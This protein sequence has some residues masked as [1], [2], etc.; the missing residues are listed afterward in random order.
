[1]TKYHGKNMRVYVDGYDISGYTNSIDVQN[2]ADTV[3][4]GAFSSTAKEYVV[5]LFDSGIEHAGFFEDTPV[6]GGH[7]VL[8]GRIGSAVHFMALIG[9]AAPGYGFA[10]SAELENMYSLEASISGAITHKSKLSNYGT[11]G[12]DSVVTVASKRSQSGTSAPIDSGAASNSGGRAYLQNFGSFGASVP[13][14]AVGSIVLIGGTDAAFTPTGTVGLA[15][16]G[17]QGVTPFG[18][19]ISFSG[20]FPRY[21]S[22]WAS[23]GTPQFALAVARG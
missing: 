17:T 8:G 16:F 9:T 4:V 5:G 20:T 10:G 18:S 23:N 15:V 21:L 19:G 13:V 22:A 2:T 7:A 3:D 1:M 12:V 11:Q 14:N 6:S